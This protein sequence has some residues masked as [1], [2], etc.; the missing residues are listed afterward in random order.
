MKILPLNPLTIA[1]A[2]LLL[3]GAAAYVYYN[4]DVLDRFTQQETPQ[5]EHE[6][7]VAEQRKQVVDEGGS[8][9]VL[10]PSS[11][12]V[13]QLEPGRVEATTEG[14]KQEQREEE[15]T[16]ITAGGRFTLRA[17]NSAIA[18]PLAQEN[19]LEEYTTRAG[20]EP[21]TLQVYRSAAGRNHTLVLS[22]QRGS[23]FYQTT[24]SYDPGSFPYGEELFED[25]VQSITFTPAGS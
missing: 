21:A 13:A 22:A 11:W 15:G 8:F 24:F 20:G 7:I 23:T 14:F 18:A 10:I 16:V 9:S 19:L 1:I 4:T 6:R 12:E 2:F 3:A 25:V 17:S 5:S